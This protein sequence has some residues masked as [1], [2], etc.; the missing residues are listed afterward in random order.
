M[1][2]RKKDILRWVTVVC[3]KTI[4]RTLIF[5]PRKTRAGPGRGVRYTAFGS[6]ALHVACPSRRAIKSLPRYRP[7]RVI[8][9][10]K[11]KNLC[12]I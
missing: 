8:Y 10:K 9:E 12:K 5:L 3:N 6:H 2:V 4:K 7:N 1:I 11:K